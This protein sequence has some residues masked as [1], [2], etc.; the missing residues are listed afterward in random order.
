M[1][2][3]SFHDINSNFYIRPKN[4]VKGLG[5]YVDGK[6]FITCDVG[7]IEDIQVTHEVLKDVIT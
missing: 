7:Y 5:A 6:C 1:E 2:L 4:T 3:I